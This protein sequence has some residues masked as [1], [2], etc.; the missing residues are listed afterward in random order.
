MSPG[1]N[2]QTHESVAFGDSDGEYKL[3]GI[4]TPP[5]CLNPP[6]GVFT[7][8]LHEHV[9]VS[10]GCVQDISVWVFQAF[11]SDFHGLSIDVDPSGCTTC[12][13]CPEI[14]KVEETLLTLASML[15]VRSR[16]YYL[17]KLRCHSCHFILMSHYIS[18]SNIVLFFSLLKIS[19]VTSWFTN[20]EHMKSL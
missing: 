7:D 15:E 11:H 16:N 9:D 3:A 19:L 20:N 18:E 2:T 5:L 12:Q 17:D 4:I 10:L 8:L 1:K 14:R 6:T 13:E